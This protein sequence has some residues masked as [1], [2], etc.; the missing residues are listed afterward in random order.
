[1]NIQFCRGVL[2]NS[3]RII[4]SQFDQFEQSLQN[5]ESR[6]NQACSKVDHLTGEFSKVEEALE[7]LKW[8]MSAFTK[9]LAELLRPFY[10]WTAEKMEG[11][12]SEGV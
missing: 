8:G 1:M 3:Q 7:S 6:T 11:M 2:T 4:K 10:N 9:S 5:I 12:I